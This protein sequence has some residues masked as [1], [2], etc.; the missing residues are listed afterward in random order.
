MAYRDRNLLYR[1]QSFYIINILYLH[2]YITQNMHF[3]TTSFMYLLFV[4]HDN[5]VYFSYFWPLA[6]VRGVVRLRSICRFPQNHRRLVTEPNAELFRQD[7]KPFTIFQNGI[8]TSQRS[9]VKSTACGNKDKCIH[10]KLMMSCWRTEEICNGTL[11]HPPRSPNRPSSH[12]R[13]LP[14]AC[15]CVQENIWKHSKA[16]RVD[17]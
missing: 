1:L 2:R 8:T 4:D 13:C 3:D 16:A 12:T 6:G 17:H 10:I 15:F 7:S 5:Y 11:D 9:E 14:P